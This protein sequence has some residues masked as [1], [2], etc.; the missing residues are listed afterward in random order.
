M[1]IEKVTKFRVDD[2]EFSTLEKAQDHVESLVDK[3]LRLS[4]ADKGFSAS[5][6]FKIS[7]VVLDNREAL[8]TLLSCKFE[9]E[10]DE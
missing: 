3:L 2:R 10:D 8:V 4:L 5:E 9:E 1:K 6:M 7:Q